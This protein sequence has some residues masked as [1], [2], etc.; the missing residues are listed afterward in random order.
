MVHNSSAGD[1]IVLV[2]LFSNLSIE[3]H[4]ILITNGKQEIIP[5][6]TLDKYINISM[7]KAIISIK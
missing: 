1:E 6:D 2:V 7:G 5:K 4:S 3:E